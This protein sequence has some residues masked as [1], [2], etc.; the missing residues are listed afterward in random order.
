[1]A[2][3]LLARHGNT[4][5]PGDTPVMVGARSDLPLVERGVGQARALGAALRAAAIDPRRVFAGPLRRTA[6]FA[7]IALEEARLTRPV[8]IDERLREID[9]GPWE[10]RSD[11][12]LEA[13]GQGEAL[14]GWRERSVWPAE[15]GWQPHEELLQARILEFAAEA[16]DG[17]PD[18]DDV[19]VVSS[20]GVL[21]Y[22]LKL[23]P[24]AFEAAVA[25]GTAKLGT[26]RLSALT[27]HEE[28]GWSLVFWNRDPE[29]IVG[30]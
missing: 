9:Y 3:L 5:G 19:L 8:M 20:N 25:E 2:R 30:A 28:D 21:R 23:V 26:G 17:L 11:A 1:M 14:A 27:H 18:E 22:F 12:E 7:R 29:D 6:D 15:A 10:G 4:F 13:A 24:G 16:V